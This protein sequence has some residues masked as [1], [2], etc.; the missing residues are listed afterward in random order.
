MPLLSAQDCVEGTGHSLLIYTTERGKCKSHWQ[1][2]GQVRAQIILTKHHHSVPGC[3]KYVICEELGQ[4]NPEGQS[5]LSSTA[6][7]HAQKQLWGGKGLLQG[8]H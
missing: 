2:Q 1:N 7:N 6:E 4:E 3:I 5:P 8:S